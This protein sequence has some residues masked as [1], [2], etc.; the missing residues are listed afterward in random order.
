MDEIIIIAKQNPD[1]LK[2]YIIKLIK[3]LEEEVQ[4]R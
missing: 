4:R 3:Q 1:D 2:E